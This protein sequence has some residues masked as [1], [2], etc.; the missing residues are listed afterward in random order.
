[1]NNYLLRV[2]CDAC[3][4]EGFVE[5]QLDGDIGVKLGDIYD[6]CNCG[7]GVLWITRIEWSM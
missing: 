4:S 6:K 7:N 2:N 3:E 5:I 1:M